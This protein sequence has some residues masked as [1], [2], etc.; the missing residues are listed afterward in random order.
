MATKTATKPTTKKSTKTDKP[1][2][3]WYDYP[4]YYDLAF[5]N[6]TVPEANFLEKVWNGYSERPV[7]R[8][9]EPACGSG[10]HVAE[11]AARGY[12]I[13]GFDLNEKSIAFA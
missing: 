13:Q 1:N 11:L 10:R 6:D 8:L 4:Q 3:E 9:L 5:Q 12:D 2:G 7:H